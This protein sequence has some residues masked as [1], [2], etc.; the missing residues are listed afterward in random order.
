MGCKHHNQELLGQPFSEVLLVCPSGNVCNFPRYHNKNQNEG[1]CM[2]Y[3]SVYE[4]Q[5]RD[6]IGFVITH[7][8]MYC[9]FCITVAMWLFNDRL[10]LTV[11][12]GSLAVEQDLITESWYGIYV[13]DFKFLSRT[14]NITFDL[15]EFM[16]MWL[17]WHHLSTCDK[18][19]VSEVITTSKN[20]LCVGYI[21]NHSVILL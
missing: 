17:I 11:T 15:S 20:L 12:H 18:S 19:L 21:V 4:C 2:R 7:R 10:L 16:D 1:E 14:E 6:I 3:K 5:L 8:D 13:L 9:I